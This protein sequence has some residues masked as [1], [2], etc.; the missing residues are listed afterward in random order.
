MGYFSEVSSTPE[1]LL[2]NALYVFENASDNMIMLQLTLIDNMLEKHEQMP[3]SNI[4]VINVSRGHCLL[5]C[6]L[7]HGMVSLFELVC[8]KKCGD[9]HAYE[10]GSGM[11]TSLFFN[12]LVETQPMYLIKQALDAGANPKEIDGLNQ[13]AFAVAGD[14][15]DIIKLLQNHVDREQPDPVDD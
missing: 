1:R 15:A 8:Q 9:M 3:T 4:N 13:D 2:S 6:A 14:R 7:T 11:K 12:W 10:G 5:R